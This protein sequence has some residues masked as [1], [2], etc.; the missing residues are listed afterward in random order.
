MCIVVYI[1]CLFVF[2]KPGVYSKCLDL[3]LCKMFMK[4]H[5]NMWI[6]QQCSPHLT[7]GKHSC[8]TSAQRVMLLVHEM[9]K[10]KTGCSRLDTT[11][12]LHAFTLH[13]STKPFHEYLTLRASILLSI[14]S[15]LH[16]DI[17]GKH[18]G[19]Q[20]YPRGYREWVCSSLHA[21][22]AFKR[23]CLQSSHHSSLGQR[24]K[25]VDCQRWQTVCD[26]LWAGKWAAFLL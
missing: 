15:S 19:R 6:N 10:C 22:I 7:C 12:L 24:T 14:D 23:M 5:R 13:V 25:G 2:F 16:M 18:I 11:L 8:I 4:L 3:A 9:W 20:N 26:T 17:W 21:D 1:I